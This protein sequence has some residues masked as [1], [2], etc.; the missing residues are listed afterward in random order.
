MQIKLAYFYFS[1]NNLEMKAAEML[2]LY[3]IPS[4]AVR[5]EGEIIKFSGIISHE[6]CSATCHM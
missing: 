3:P 2:K 1:A 5:D 4:L 6:N